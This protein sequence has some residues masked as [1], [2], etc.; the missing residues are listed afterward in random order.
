MTIPSNNS[1]SSP[2]IS[3][4]EISEE[5][6]LCGSPYTGQNEDIQDDPTPFVW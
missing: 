3:V 2:A 1:Y 6:V 5:D 4:Q